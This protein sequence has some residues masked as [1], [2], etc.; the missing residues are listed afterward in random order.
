MAASLALRLRGELR[1]SASRWPRNARTASAF[2][3]LR[4]S[5]EGE[6]RRFLHRNRRKSRKVSRYAATVF[7]LRSRC[8]TRCSVK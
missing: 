2:N 4:G 3:A 5:S 6:V 8:P 7:A 1:R